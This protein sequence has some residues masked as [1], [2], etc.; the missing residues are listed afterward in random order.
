MVL[1]E[2]GSG[3]AA[4]LVLGFFGY[5]GRGWTP[6][7]GFEDFELAKLVRT[8]VIYGAAGALVGATGEP[9][10][11]GNIVDA[12]GA[13]VFLGEVAERV[14]KRLQRERERRFYAETGAGAGSG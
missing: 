12:T 11:Q 2:I 7:D 4:G 9:L 10:T 14:V 13:T 6:D 8:L 5:F 3:L 1:Q